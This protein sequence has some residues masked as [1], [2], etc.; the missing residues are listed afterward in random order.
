MLSESVICLLSF[1]LSFSFLFW[2][3]DFPSHL[4]VLLSCYHSIHVLFRG[5]GP[6]R[7][8]YGRPMGID[9]KKTTTGLK[10]AQWFQLG[11]KPKTLPDHHNPV[12]LILSFFLFFFRFT[13]LSH[14]PFQLR[15][16]LHA[17]IILLKPVQLVFQISPSSSS[18]FRWIS[19]NLS[20]TCPRHITAQKQKEKKCIIVFIYLKK[21]LFI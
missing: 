12:I 8:R 9:F 7:P 19:Q 14:F 6:H 17:A 15:D 13:C 4:Y 1:P 18:D 5:S 20:W 16:F 3:S 21:I 11:G 2:A 10:V